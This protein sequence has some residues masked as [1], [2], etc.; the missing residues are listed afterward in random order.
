MPITFA[1]CDEAYYS[2]ETAQKI[3]EVRKAFHAGKL[4]T[5]PLA[6]CELDLNSVSM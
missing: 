4:V 2:L 5:K 3:D 1:N 6:A